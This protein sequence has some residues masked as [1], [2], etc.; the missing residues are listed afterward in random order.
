MYY[1]RGPNK[2][3]VALNVSAVK[4][5]GIAVIESPSHFLA[6]L[7][8]VALIKSA[9]VLSE[10]QLPKFRSRMKRLRP[11]CSQAKGM[12][13]CCEG[14]LVY[15]PRRQIRG[16]RNGWYPASNKGSNACEPSIEADDGFTR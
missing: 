2:R 10:N 15:Q 8:P 14:C 11:A 13:C 6:K 9:V 7:T 3:D 4:I 12:T 5:P 16:R 1:S